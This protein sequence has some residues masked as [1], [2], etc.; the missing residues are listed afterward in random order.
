MV[1]MLGSVR[2]ASHGNRTKDRVTEQHMLKR[3][4]RSMCLA[5]RWWVCISVRSVCGR[6]RKGG[7][8]AVFSV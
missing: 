1:Y 7:V 8:R 4:V 5:E 6:D 3:S 2:C